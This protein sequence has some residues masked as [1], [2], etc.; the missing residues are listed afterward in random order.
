MQSSASTTQ[1]VPPQQTPPDLFA[2]V[3]FWINDDVDQTT[4]DEIR[5]LLFQGGAQEYNPS[6]TPS[7]SAS[8]STQLRFELDAVTHVIANSVEFEEY[9]HCIEPTLPES[10]PDSKRPLVVTPDWVRRSA[11]LKIRLKEDRFSCRAEMIFSGLCVTA[12][13]SEVSKADRELISSIVAAYGGLWRED[14]FFDVNVLLTTSISSN[15]LARILNSP[16]KQTICVAPQWISD[17]WRLQKRLPLDSYQFLPGQAKLPPCF[18]GK[19]ASGSPL[20]SPR[21]DRVAMSLVGEKSRSS[22]SAGSA[23]GVFRG[24]SVLL[25]RDV[26]R[27]S[28]QQ[29]RSLEHFVRH[30]GG[31]IRR[32]PTDLDG[33][34]QAARN[35]DYV[36]CRYREVQEF[37]EAIRQSKQVGNLTWLIWVVSNDRL[38]DPRQEPLHFPVPRTPIAEF[39][40]VAITISNYRGATRQYLTKM[41]KLMGATFSGTL[42]AQTSLCVAANLASEKTERARDWGVPVVNHK[43]IVDSFL[44]WAPVE[45]AKLKYIDFP[46]GVDYNLD[47]GDTRVTDESLG[48]WIDDAISNNEPVDLPTSDPAVPSLHYAADETSSAETGS[49]GATSEPQPASDQ[50]TDVAEPADATHI[51][52]TS[53][54]ATPTRRHSQGEANV[55]SEADATDGAHSVPASPS[56]HRGTKRSRLTVLGESTKQ[57]SCA[58]AELASAD[59]SATKKLKTAVVSAAEVEGEVRVATSNY[60]LKKTDETKL[61]AAG[62]VVV[63]S[64]ERAHVLVTPKLSRSP[65]M[66]YAIASGAVAIV[67]PDWLG[68]CMKQRTAVSTA[69]YA[70]VDREGEKAY[71]IQLADVLERRQS[72]FAQGIY[73]G[74]KFWLGRGVDDTGSLASL[75][76]AAGG[77]LG[78]GKW[79]EEALREDPEHCHLVVEED[80]AAEWR[81]LVG[82]STIDGEPLK[83]FKKQLVTDCIFEQQPRWDRHLVDGPPGAKTTPSKRVRTPKRISR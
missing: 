78:Q 28:E 15:K 14:H 19:T 68:A 1:A 58:S 18:A 51:E 54:P 72:I 8:A 60:K 52:H 21:R 13:K 63:D 82:T 65:K 83:L 38:S 10:S 17:S 40:G 56:S 61:R 75:I 7:G 48:P 79:D 77:K 22:A 3:Q 43:Y 39:Q 31:T 47:V 29:L 36:V 35:S 45:R 25:A 27:A 81:P 66:L 23:R 12:S 49:G 53:P 5:K 59:A 4:H 44:A 26:C 57:P 70:L 6:S 16:G 33:I 74:H 11:H 46:D 41:V 55:S 80:H 24:K 69:D 64:I 30:S 42:T 50:T 67:S 2:D 62:V 9:R 20:T 34:A 73:C 37:R 71:G 76:G 32:A